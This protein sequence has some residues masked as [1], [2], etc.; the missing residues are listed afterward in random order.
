MVRIPAVYLCCHIGSP[1]IGKRL[2]SRVYLSILVRINK[3]V[4]RNTVRK[5]RV[6]EVDCEHPCYGCK[7][8]H[9]AAG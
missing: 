4:P 3:Q 8:N 1:V 2:F 7:F 9:N 5:V 6:A